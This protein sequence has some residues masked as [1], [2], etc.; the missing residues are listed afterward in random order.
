[1]NRAITAEKETSRRA[2]PAGR[3][4]DGISNAPAP[5]AA[6]AAESDAVN[7][8]EISSD[9]VRLPYQQ[10]LDSL[11]QVCEARRTNERDLR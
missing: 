5:P 3:G 6:A 7:G 8:L 2:L 10:R 1:V 9:G 11:S 4:A